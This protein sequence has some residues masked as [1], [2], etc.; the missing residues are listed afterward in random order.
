MQKIITQIEGKKGYKIDNLKGKLIY[1]VIIDVE[2]GED[3]L[4]L[5]DLTLLN[6]PDA[7]DVKTLIPHTLG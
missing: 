5:I 4:N 2:I 1:W 7:P 6:D 3:D